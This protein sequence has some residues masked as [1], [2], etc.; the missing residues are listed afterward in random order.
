M[1]NRAD[2]VADDLYNAIVELVTNIA[3]IDPAPD[4]PLGQL[5]AGLSAACETY[6]EAKGWTRRNLDLDIP[7]PEEDDDD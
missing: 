6:E 7:E 5:F 2:K 3:E 1:P 4:T